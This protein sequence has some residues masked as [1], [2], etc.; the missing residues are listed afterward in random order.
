LG[1]CLVVLAS[2]NHPTTQ[3]RNHKA[4]EPVMDDEIVKVYQQ[5]ENEAA[6]R[7]AKKDR[8]GELRERP[9]GRWEI[10]TRMPFECAAGMMDRDSDAYQSGEEPR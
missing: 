2:R 8:G 3:P 1:I 9:D 10:V 5:F 7:A 6:A 4:K